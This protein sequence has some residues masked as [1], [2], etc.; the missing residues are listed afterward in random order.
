LKEKIVAAPKD[1]I[2]NLDQLEME[3]KDNPE[4]V[5]A[6]I[7]FGTALLK[8]GFIKRAEE[9]L[10][11][12]TELDPES[13]EAWV[14]LGGV[15]L[16]SWD[17][18]G[19]VEVNQKA[20]SCDPDCVQPH[21]N[22]GLGHMYLGNAEEVVRCFTKVLELDPKNPGGLYHLA[23][24]LC[25]IGK[26]EEAE[27]KLQEAVNLGYSPQPE[28]IKELDRKKKI[29]EK[30]KDGQANIFEFGPNTNKEYKQ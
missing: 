24:G 9:T 4:S 8:A 29:R 30:Q 25:A 3:L 18:K 5:R 14:H 28:L 1:K 6:H 23:V 15:L 13:V 10:R 20:A 7:K 21:Y 22:E 17:F 11:K 16:T 2:G 19:C 26:D 27:I 12:A